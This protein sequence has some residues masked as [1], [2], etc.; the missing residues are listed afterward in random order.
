MDFPYFKP[1]LISCTERTVRNKRFMLRN[2]VRCYTNFP[3][4]AANLDGMFMISSGFKFSREEKKLQ[5]LVN[6]SLRR[7]RGFIIMS[8]AED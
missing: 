4:R 6:Q 3:L 1:V 7:T 5:V 2:P 8:N